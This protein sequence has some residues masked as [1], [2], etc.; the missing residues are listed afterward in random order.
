[1]FGLIIGNYAV[2]HY[3]AHVRNVVLPADK[4]RYCKVLT[5]I[6][7]VTFVRCHFNFSYLK[8]LSLFNVLCEVAVKKG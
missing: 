6:L 1:M 2:S 3:H 4:F 5:D 7:Y 8:Y